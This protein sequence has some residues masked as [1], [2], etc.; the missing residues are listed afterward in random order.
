MSHSAS[1]KRA[2]SL[3][4]LLY[5]ESPRRPTQVPRTRR[6][7]RAFARVAATPRVRISLRSSIP[8][9]LA[10][11]VCPIGRHRCSEPTAAMCLM[12]SWTAVLA[13]P[14]KPKT[15][16]V[17][18]PN[19]F[20]RNSIAPCAP[21]GVSFHLRSAARAFLKYSLWTLQALVLC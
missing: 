14:R 12:V 11:E 8:Y 13:S 7:M 16:G 4:V 6:R 20:R 17:T 15:K 9:A 5:W 21:G 10:W 2:S 19:W 3:A 18:V 1:R